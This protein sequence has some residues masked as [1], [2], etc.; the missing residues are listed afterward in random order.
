MAREGRRRAAL[1]RRRDR[2]RARGRRTRA[3]GARVRR[4]RGTMPEA[5][6]QRLMFASGR[7]RPGRVVLLALFLALL[8]GA[9]RPAEPVS[10]VRVWPSTDY[11]RLTLET[12]APLRYTLLTL[13]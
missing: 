12:A 9:A 4:D 11:T 1:A 2:A 6:A 7:A 3:A 5:L 8:S 10:A 13:K